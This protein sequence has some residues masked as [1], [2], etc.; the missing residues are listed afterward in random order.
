MI[1]ANT[2]ASKEVS[3]YFHGGKCDK[4]ITFCSSVGK[5]PMMISS[6]LWG[7]EWLYMT[8]PVSCVDLYVVVIMILTR[9]SSHMFK[10]FINFMQF[11]VK[12]NVSDPQEE[13]NTKERHILQRAVWPARP[14]NHKL[15]TL[16][17]TGINWRMT[18]II[19]VT[20][21]TETDP[22]ASRRLHLSNGNTVVS[23]SVVST[24][25]CTAGV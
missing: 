25:R 7:R 5:F 12:T 4:R 22:G 8:L 18:G 24:S 21:T 2:D 14:G 11:K 16:T 13:W 15:L 3:K 17:V 10:I 23:L 6:A 19:A 9:F 20:L 1:K